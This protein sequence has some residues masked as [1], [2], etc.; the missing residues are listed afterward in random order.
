MRD[1]HE[2]HCHIGIGKLNGTLREWYWWPGMA[3]TV[4]ETVSTCPT[5]QM[6]KAK[7]LA[8]KAPLPS[9]KGVAPFQGWHIDLAGPFPADEEGNKYLMLAVNPLSKWVEAYLLPDKY[10][11]RTARALW[12]LIGR[13]GKPQWVTTDNGQEF[14]G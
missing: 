10:S 12:E 1:F 13:W 5:C 6:D 8:D 7:P 4:I 2:S 14:D 11:W 9:Y 3:T